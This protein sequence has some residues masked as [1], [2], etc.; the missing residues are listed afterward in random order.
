MVAGSAGPVHRLWTGAIHVVDRRDQ[1]FRL[2]RAA[3]GRSAQSRLRGRRAA[4]G[5]SVATTS[6]RARALMSDRFE[7]L[8]ALAETYDLLR[9]VIETRKDQVER[10]SWGLRPR[11]GATAR[12][13]AHKPAHAVFRAARRPALLRDLAAHVA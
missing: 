8:R 5:F 12:A 6:S 3:Y 11:R 13:F 10:M 4:D 2:V 7:D 9:L 1:S